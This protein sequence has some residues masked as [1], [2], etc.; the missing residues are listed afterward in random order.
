MVISILFR[1]FDRNMIIDNI[2]LRKGIEYLIEIPIE[3][4]IRCDEFITFELGLDWGS[5]FKEYIVE[6]YRILN[7]GG[8]IHI[9]E[10][11]KNYDTEENIND[12]IKLLTEI[13]F[14]IVGGI[15]RR[16]KFIYLTGIKI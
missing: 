5:N 13:G 14:K 9:A 11:L 2:I 15:E 10:P 1:T 12:L 8:I 16:S 7:F 3:S 6:A 4:I